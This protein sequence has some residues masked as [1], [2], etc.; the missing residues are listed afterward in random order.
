MT[1]LELS[2]SEFDSYYGRYINK[3]SEKNHLRT[4][5]KTGKE[6]VIAFFTSIPEDKLEYRYE[7]EKWTIKE[8]LQHLIDSERIFIY[9]CFRIAR[10]DMT[11]LTDFNQNIYVNPS[12]A[13]FKTIKE[14]LSE[15]EIN[16]DNS[17]CLLNS[18]SDEDL[19]FTGISD[20]KAMSARAAAFSIIGHEIWHMDIIKEHY[21]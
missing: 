4:G 20:G 5:F 8:I 21:L 19:S 7:S 12:K 17:I 13:N 18:L 6:N 1:R 3:L 16:R 10:R 11:S 9:R 2:T 15:F 14:L